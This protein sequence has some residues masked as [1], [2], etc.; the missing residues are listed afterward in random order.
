MYIAC[1]GYFML[2]VGYTCE[3][4]TELHYN[5]V[6]GIDIFLCFIHFHQQSSSA[7]EQERVFPTSKSCCHFFAATGASCYSAS[8]ST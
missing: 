7:F 1:L 4:F 6:G 8:T 2:C 5:I 3:N